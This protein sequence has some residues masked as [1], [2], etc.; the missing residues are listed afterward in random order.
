VTRA[1]CSHETSV[2]EN[3]AL[4]RCEQKRSSREVCRFAS[5]DARMAAH[6]YLDVIEYI[7]S[8]QL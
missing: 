1:C 6:G 3:R 7:K 8:Y 2:E 4:G 5:I